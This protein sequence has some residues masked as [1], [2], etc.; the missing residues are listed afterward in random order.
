MLGEY[1]SMGV[2][3]LFG[4][5]LIF[6]ATYNYS[7]HY[8][9]RAYESADGKRLGFQFHNI[10]GNVGKKVECMKGN[11]TA[12]KV[13]SFRNKNAVTRS[14]MGSSLPINVKGVKFNVL[15]DQ[16]GEFDSEGRLLE[17]LE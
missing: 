13:D 9:Y 5:G 11:A 14:M 2:A 8:V 7:H 4:T 6:A 12:L 17:M 10:L 15:L 3:G 16:A 1:P